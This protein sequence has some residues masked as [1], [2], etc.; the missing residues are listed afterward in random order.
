MKEISRR[1]FIKGAAASALSVAALGKVGGF[2]TPAAA[3]EAKLA[4]QYAPFDK[5]PAAYLNP[6]RTDYRT[7]DKELTTLFSPFKI[8]NVELNHRMVKSAAG[9][10]TYLPGMTDEL[11]TYYFNLAKGG[12]ELIFVESVAF[13]EVPESGEYDEETRAYLEKLVN[14]CAEYGAKLGYQIS[15]FGMGEN[16]MTIEDIHAKQARMIQVAKGLYEVGF[17]VIE[18]NCAGFNMPA[19][20]LSRFHNTRVDEYGGKSVENRARFVTEILTQLKADCPDLAVQILID[21][22][23]ENDNIANNPTIM[24]LDTD[25]TTPHTKPLTIEEGIAAAKL[26]EA[27]GADSMHLRIGPL[28]HHVAQFA[29]DLYFILNGVEGATGFGTQ[30]DFT[31]AFQGAAIGDT[32][33]C[34]IALDIAARYKKEL[35]IPVGAVTYMD[36][37]HAP[38]F[39]EQALEDGKVDFLLMNRPLTVDMDYVN[40]L[41]E[42]RLDEIAPCTRCLHCH[43]GSNEMNAMFCYCRV[44]ALTQRVMREGGPATYELPKADTVKKVMVI[45]GGPAGMEAARIA[46]MRGHDVTL[47][48]KKGMLG[49]LLDFASYVKGPHENLADLKNYLIRQLEITGVTVKTGVEVDQALIEAEAPDAVILAAGGLRPELEV[50]GDGSAPIIGMDDFLF[51]E[52]GENVIVYGSNAQAFDA[53]LWLTVHKKKVSI[54]TPNT[55]DELDIQQSQHAKR[56]MT[57]A[58]YAL[59][60]HSWPEAAIKEVKDGKAIVSI[61]AG[62]DME[63][64]CDAI[65]NAGDMLPNTALLDGISVAETYAIGD[66]ANPFN[67]ALAIRGGNDAGRAV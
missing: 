52:M 22:I 59:G 12:V 58:L 33:G 41:R 29:S 8:G 61:E 31:Q 6:Q 28:G 44:N 53:A 37:A 10:A 48:E 67:I 57:T 23:E 65:V 27:A 55:A 66:C 38:D 45:G 17:Q 11:L 3:E 32:S 20:F 50:K 47:Y 13:L 35:S 36:P 7:H 54:V 62:V 39:F 24:T 42:G 25:V 2:A 14:G 49:G 18:Y 19:H 56:M 34:G 46:A 1:N 21:C 5:I 16:E 51:A 43:S 63:I 64:P 40:K 4:E 15:G 60:V 30:Y 26:F 9:S